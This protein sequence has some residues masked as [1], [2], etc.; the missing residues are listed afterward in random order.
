MALLAAPVHI[1]A[2]CTDRRRPCRAQSH[3]KHRRTPS[4]PSAWSAT[5]ARPGKLVME[6]GTFRWTA[7]IVIA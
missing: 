7:P 2:F 3:Q 1:R 4:P 5:D 6:W